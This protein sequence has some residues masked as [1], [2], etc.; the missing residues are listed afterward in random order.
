MPVVHWGL[1]CMCQ[2]SQWWRNCERCNNFCLLFS[3]HYYQSLLHVLAMWSSRGMCIN[4]NA[5]R[6]CAGS[7]LHWLSGVQFPLVK[8]ALNAT[9]CTC[10]DSVNSSG[11]KQRLPATVSALLFYGRRFF[12][13]CST[14]GDSKQDSSPAQGPK[15]FRYSG[16]TA[17]G[18]MVVHCCMWA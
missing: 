1:H 13:S 12:F 3:C 14:R 8:E 11:D 7:K 4:W 15:Y 5:P 6:V 17:I 16:R 18:M 2:N 10:R 9:T